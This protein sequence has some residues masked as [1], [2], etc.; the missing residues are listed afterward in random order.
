MKIKIATAFLFF[1]I[2]TSIVA[3]Q[4][5]NLADLSAFA[6]AGNNWEIV[7]A[8][9]GLYNSR[10]LN[11]QPGAGILHNK[12]HANG[13]K[14]EDLFTIFNHGDINLSLDFM[15]P[16]GSN[17]GI[18]LQGRYEI[19][20]FDSWGVKKP[21]VHDC[22]AI[23]ERWDEGR[24]K[25]NEGFEGHSPRQNVCFAPGLWQH[26]E[27]RF[28]APRFDKNGKKISN[29][30]F[31]KVVQNGFII[32]ENVELLG[33]TRGAIAAEEVALGPV[34]IQGDHGEVAFKNIKYELLD[35]ELATIQSISYKY[36]EGKFEKIPETV[37]EKVNTKGDLDKINYRVAEKNNDFLLQFDGKISIPQSDM[38]TFNLPITGQA[39]FK[40]DGKKIIDSQGHKWRNEE[41]TAI[42]ELQKGTHS[43]EVLYTKSF[44]WG[45]RALGLFIQRQ[46]TLPQ[47]LHEYISLPDPDPVGLIELK[48]DPSK[49]VLQRSFVYFNGKKRTHAINIGLPNGRNFSYDL[50]RGA[51]LNAW[52]GKFLN[53]TEMWFERGE[54]Q[55]AEPLAA[56]IDFDGKNPVISKTNGR[57]P[58]SLSVEAEW[59]YK[60]YSFDKAK[61]PV[62]TYNHK[63]VIVTDKISAE[64]S[65]GGLLREFN[66]SDYLIHET[67]VRAGVG[68]EVKLIENGIYKVDNHFVKIAPHFTPLISDKDENGFLSLLIPTISRNIYYS[69]IW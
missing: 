63:N 55:I 41:N 23:Y 45:G 50:Q 25:G 40:I 30:K 62:F 1:C 36:Y 59:I 6:Q 33:P 58:D 11:T 8:V 42:I 65:G 64:Q 60:G 17:S 31:V 2:S 46:G 24:G 34:R 44:S 68:I 27:I 69:I 43:F 18:Y 35:K 38:Y 53:A 20:L 37:P 49:P 29:A 3:Q 12:P 22:G 26:L 48:T 16:K 66:F 47:A 13:T 4:T 51:M 19:Q 15:M 56:K 52:N 7:S 32:H 14:S 28:Q 5:I 57:L 21:K 10:I 39:V 54:P 61:N 67:F 9:S